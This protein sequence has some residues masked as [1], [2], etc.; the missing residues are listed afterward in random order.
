MNHIRRNPVTAM[1]LG[2]IAIL[3]VIYGLLI[4]ALM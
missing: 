2:Y 1:I 3:M 4:I